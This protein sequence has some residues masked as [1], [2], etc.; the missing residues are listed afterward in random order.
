VKRAWATRRKHLKADPPPLTTD[1]VTLTAG[2]NFMTQRE[3]ILRE[4]IE[5]TTGPRNRKYGDPGF[6]FRCITELKKTFWGYMA[7]SD[8]KVEQNSPFGHAIDMVLTNL[9]R[10]ATSPT[11]AFERDRFVDGATY[12]AIAFEVG[13]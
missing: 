9:A 2:S 1:A 11:T 12:L 7:M 13:E 8:K 10:I 6:N 4:G 5:V 3:S